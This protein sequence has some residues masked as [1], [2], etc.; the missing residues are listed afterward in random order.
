M[1]FHF[2]LAS[3]F[4]LAVAACGSASNANP[5]AAP[6]KVAPP[7][8]AP[9]NTVASGVSS[10]DNPADAAKAYFVA[11]YSGAATDQILCSGNPTVTAGLKQMGNAVSAGIAAGNV[12]I[13]MSGLTYETANQTSDSADVK[14]SGQI[15][16]TSAA[17]TAKASDF[18]PQILKM[19]NDNGWKVC[20]MGKA[21]Q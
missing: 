3:L 5:T 15:M 18:P 7:A 14:V 4:T 21:T 12:K 20:G 9:T 10:A 2:L 19:K 17:G 8:L 1:K 16:T 13:D 11:L 6:A